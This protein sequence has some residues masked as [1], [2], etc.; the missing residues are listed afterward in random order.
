MVLRGAL[1]KS[2]SNCIDS[3]NVYCMLHLPCHFGLWNTFLAGIATSHYVVVAICCHR[4]PSFFMSFNSM[5]SL[6]MNNDDKSMLVSH[7]E[8]VSHRVFMVHSFVFGY[9]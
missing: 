1:P 5:K 3:Q 4:M 6:I 8:Y 9:W 2:I 7:V